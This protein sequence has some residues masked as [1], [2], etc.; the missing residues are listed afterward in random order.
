MYAKKPWLKFYGAV[1]PHIDYP[2]RPLA[3]LLEDAV[4]EFPDQNAYIY[5]GRQCTYREL[6]RLTHRLAGALHAL[7]IK[8]GD[9]VAVM[10]P[11]CP[12]FVAAY[13]AVAR[14]GAIVVNTNPMYTEREILHQV[15][16]SG[17]ETIVTFVEAAPRVLAVRDQ[18]PLRHV[19]LTSLQDK[20]PEL[21]SGTLSMDDLLASAWP[22]VPPVE[23]NAREDVAVLQYTGGTT[24]ISK[25]AMLT[26]YNLVSNAVQVNEWCAGVEMERILTVLPLFHVYGMTCCMNLALITGGT[27]I[28]LPR[29]DAK[30][31]LEAIKN[32]R[33]TFFPGV[34]TMY[35]AILNYPGLD[36]YDLTVVPFF[37]SGAAPMPLEVME[38]IRRR[39]A[40]SNSAYSEGYGLSEASPVTHS[41]PITTTIKPGSIGVP[42]PDT[43]CRIVDLETGEGDMPV[44]EPGELIIQGPQV[45]KGYWNNP[46][47]TAKAL[48]NG[49]LYTGDIA[50][51]DED[52]YFY[53]VDRKKDLIIAGGYNI[54]PREVEE[55]L[56]ELA[57]VKEAAV[58]G[59][60]D[61]YRGETVKAYI[62]FKEG[63]TL[64]AE[65][66]IQ[67]CR[68]RLAAYKV[69]KL[70]EFREQLP[71]SAVGKL[72]RR[73]LVE[74][75]RQKLSS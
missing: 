37:N 56:Y 71:K 69:P 1:R 31:V 63:Q 48:R 59:V 21:P 67:F 36:Q 8:K 26:H 2:V 47:E 54:Y 7:G 22:E 25:G 51:M 28:L 72:L 3:S 33:P 46:G 43:G 9:R 65:E 10:L 13:Y 14:L 75:E 44:G 62:V 23:V 32:Y 34:P 35:T 73:Q 5:Y 15:R 58:A 74:E 24:G 11:N 29:F 64:T 57:Q 42:Y 52:G 40:G 61:R 41:N 27:M 49:W 68:T 30:E 17:V 12:Q 19:I 20:K 16:D 70:V 55:V 38:A 4:Q 53:I 18:T 60:P 66:V 45:M 39:L 50:R 6:G